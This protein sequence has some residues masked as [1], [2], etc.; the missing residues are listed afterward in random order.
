VIVW[1]NGYVIVRVKFGEGEDVRDG[2]FQGAGAGGIC[3]TFPLGHFSPPCTPQR[4]ILVSA[5]AG[6]G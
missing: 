4:A 3:P 6:F 1:V 2:S 5:A